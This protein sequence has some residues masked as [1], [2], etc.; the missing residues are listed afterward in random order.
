[1]PLVN[2]RRRPARERE[3]ATLTRLKAK[4]PENC[5]AGSYQ[6]LARR[7][8]GVVFGGV[9]FFHQCSGRFHS[10]GHA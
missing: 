6:V 1:M 7:V 9:E 3:W 2:G 5:G 8:G 10:G 4:R